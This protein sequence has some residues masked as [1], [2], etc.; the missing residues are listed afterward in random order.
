MYTELL[1][2]IAIPVLYV[3]NVKVGDFGVGS[4]FASAN[5]S[6]TAA[7]PHSLTGVGATDWALTVLPLRWSRTTTPPWCSAASAHHWA[8]SDHHCAYQQR[9]DA[10]GAW[11]VASLEHRHCRRQRLPTRDP[12][13][14]V[15]RDDRRR[16]HRPTQSPRHEGRRDRLG[17][18]HCRTT[19]ELERDD[20]GRG[21]T[22]RVG[23]GER[24]WTADECPTFGG[25]Y[26]R[27]RHPNSS[28]DID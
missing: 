12:A 19:Q 13:R 24:A 23:R 26:L 14:T 7:I 25:L 6:R 2:N 11:L 28:A 4:L 10:A 5:C 20:H 3:G 17:R 15:L 16:H 21:R 27:A 22:Q 9:T 18:P 1:A 8:R